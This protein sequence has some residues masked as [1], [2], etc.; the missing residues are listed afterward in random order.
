M[1]V[2]ELISDLMKYPK[3]SKVLMITSACHCTGEVFDTGS[4]I[5]PGEALQLKAELFEN[6]LIME[7]F[8][9]RVDK[10]PPIF[11][12]MKRHGNVIDN[13]GTN[14]DETKLD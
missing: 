13:I 8:D 5:S 10:C 4:Y 12:R 2:E 3:D 7:V 14:Y 1:T 6:P 11:L 9:E